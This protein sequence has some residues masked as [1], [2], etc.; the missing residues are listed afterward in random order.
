MVLSSAMLLPSSLVL[1]GCLY[2]SLNS[3]FLYRSY[4]IVS[5]WSYMEWIYFSYHTHSLI[6]CM[7]LCLCSFSTVWNY[8]CVHSVG[9]FSCVL[10]RFLRTAFNPLS[11]HWNVSQLI[12][13]ISPIIS[14]QLSVYFPMMF[15]LVVDWTLK[16]ACVDSGFWF[17]FLRCAI[18]TVSLKGRWFP[19]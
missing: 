7:W 12:V 10:H 19:W 6:L 3:G 1:L 18:F 5:Y 17:V 14:F 4:S 2:I 16:L 13:F 9:Q 15:L 11:V 8:L